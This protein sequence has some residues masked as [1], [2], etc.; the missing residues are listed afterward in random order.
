M[1]A[2]A[3]VGNPDLLLADEPIAS[4]DPY[5]Q[6]ETMDFLRQ[7]IDRGMGAMVT[8]HDLTLATR[9]CDRI[10]ILASGAVEDSGPPKSVLTAEL[11]RRIY[12]VEAEISNSEPD[13]VLP[14]KTLDQSEKKAL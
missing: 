7:Q 12:S 10:V 2:R 4:L 14:M 6:L 8:M 5:H 11:M 3:L 9:Y 13:Y 1:L